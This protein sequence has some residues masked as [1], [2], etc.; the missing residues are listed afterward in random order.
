[1]TLEPSPEVA[2]LAW[3]SA[4]LVRLIALLHVVLGLWMLAADRVV[5]AMIV[6]TIGALQF[7][8]AI[9]LRLGLRTVLV[10]LAMTGTAISC[11]ALYHLGAPLRVLTL[12]GGCIAVVMGVWWR[13]P[14]GGRPIVW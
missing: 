12:L 9:S 6:I 8:A 4:G 13:L 7:M 5:W 14:R 11:V 2:T 10:P 1:M 3:F